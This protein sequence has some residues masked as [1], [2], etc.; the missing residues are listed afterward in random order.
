VPGEALNPAVPDPLFLGCFA[1]G[2]G[3]VLGCFPYLGFSVKARLSEISPL[4]ALFQHLP[5]IPQCC[6]LA[7]WWANLA[8]MG[9]WAVSKGSKQP[10]ARFFGCRGIGAKP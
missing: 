8:A 1:P 5:H 9:A 10:A 6:A 4:S 7:W 2:F 3:A